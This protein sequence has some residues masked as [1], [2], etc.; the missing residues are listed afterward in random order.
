MLENVLQN[1]TTT[2]SLTSLTERGLISVFTSW[3]MKLCLWAG[4][5]SEEKLETKWQIPVL[6]YCIVVRFCQDG[7]MEHTLQCL[8]GLFNAKFVL[9][10]EEATVVIIQ[11]TLVFVTVGHFT[12]TNLRDS[13]FLSYVTVATDMYLQHQVGGFSYILF[14]SSLH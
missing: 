9:M 5:D 1:V 12:F 6:T 4:T 8:M 2:S 11:L 7:L 10:E 3:R 14:C 13:M